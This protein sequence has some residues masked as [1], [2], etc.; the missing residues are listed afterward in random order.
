[1]ASSTKEELAQMIAQLQDSGQNA[2]TCITAAMR[3]DRNPYRNEAK[4]LQKK[5]DEKQETIMLA[6][7]TL[8]KASM[9]LDECRAMLA[10]SGKVK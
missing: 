2:G 3:K 7:K 10:N 4:E 8:Q 9:I 6:K 1:M 5:L